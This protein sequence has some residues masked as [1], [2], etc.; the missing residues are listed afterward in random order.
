MHRSATDLCR[1]LSADP[2]VGDALRTGIVYGPTRNHLVYVRADLHDRD[3]LER[4]RPLLTAARQ[5]HESLQQG[6]TADVAFGSPRSSVY[7]YEE[8]VVAQLLAEA[9]PRGILLSFDPDL[10]VDY[11]A[12]VND[13]LTHFPKL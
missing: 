2:Q 9:A 3:P 12:F 10:D 4:L 6:T 5:M 1:T 13:C 7:V 11:P 8:L